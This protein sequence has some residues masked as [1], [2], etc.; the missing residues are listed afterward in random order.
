M[1]GDELKCCLM[2]DVG[3]AL[4][5]RVVEGGTKKGGG[6]WWGIYV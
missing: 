4:F 1:E 3:E 6:R 2:M 5:V